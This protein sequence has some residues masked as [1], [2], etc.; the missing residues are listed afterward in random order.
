MNGNDTFRILTAK[1]RIN[2]AAGGTVALRWYDFNSLGSDDG[3][4][5]DSVTAMFKNG[6]VGGVGVGKVAQAAT[7]PVSIINPATNGS[8]AISCMLAQ[9]SALN[10]HVYDLNGREVAAQTFNATK[11]DNRLQLH[12]SLAA[13]TY[14][15]R[16]DDGKEWGSVKAT[17]Q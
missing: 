9:A 13:G 7:L 6:T 15:I 11:G 16:V 5:I 14:I 1:F 2:L 12:T 4:A 10:A 3:L 8:F 17:M